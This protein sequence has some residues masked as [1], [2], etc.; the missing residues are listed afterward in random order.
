MNS[1]QGCQFTAKVFVDF[2]KE[3]GI[4]QSMSKSG[5]PYDNAPMERHFNSLKEELIYRKSF[6]TLEEQKCD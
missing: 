5:C 3:M 1:D 4:K 6:E 2:C